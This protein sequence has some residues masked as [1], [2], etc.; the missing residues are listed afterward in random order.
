MKGLIF[1]EF[2]EEKFGLEVLDRLTSLPSLQNKGAY[3]SVGNYSHGE[4]LMMLDELHT[5]ADLPHKALIMAFA[6]WMFEVFLRIHPEFFERIDNSFDFL[7]GIETV[8][9]SEVRRLY[10]DARLPDFECERRTETEL[11]MDYSSWRPFADLAEGLIQASSAYFN[12]KVEVVR[13][14]GPTG[15]GCSARFI[16][17]RLS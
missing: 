1:T 11:V 14:S 13:E 16:L 4:M 10:P 17:R 7:F 9:H 5:G 3:S 15:D 12:D 2:L 8:I 6:E